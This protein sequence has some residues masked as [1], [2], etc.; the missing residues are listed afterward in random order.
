MEGSSESLDATVDLFSTAPSLSSTVKIYEVSYP[1]LNSRIN[2]LCFSITKVQ[3]IKI[4]DD[5]Y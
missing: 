3:M 5:T 2:F 1:K 4:I